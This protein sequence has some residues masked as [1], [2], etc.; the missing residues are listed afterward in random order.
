M[1]PSSTLADLPLDQLLGETRSRVLDLLRTAPQAIADLAGAME[2]SEEAV[3]RHLRVLE[4][5]RLITSELQR[6]GGRGRPSAQYRLTERGQRLYPDRTVD[7]ANELWEYLESQHGRPGVLGFMRWRQRRQGE[8]YADEL[9]DL[10]GGLGERAAKLA[11]LLSDDGFLADTE[12]VTAPD[13]RQTLQ[14]TQSH[15]AVREVAAEHPEICAFE[16]ALF[17]DLLGTRVSRRRTIAGG[18]TRC[19]CT[20]DDSGEAGGTARAAARTEPD[21]RKPQT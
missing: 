8:R 9:E 18:D 16:A 15:C 1:T 3:R 4:R 11:E 21:A 14:L 7:F 19:V 20:I 17:R 2:L 10:P 6:Q 5:D 12:V 13:G